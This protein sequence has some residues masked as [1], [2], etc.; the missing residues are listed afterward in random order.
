MNKDLVKELAF[1]EKHQDELVARHEGKFV[2]ISGEAVVGVYASEMEAYIEAQKTH[3]LGTF[4]I[5]QCIPGTEAYTKTF[6]SRVS[7]PR[8]SC[9]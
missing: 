1:F 9:R 7:F 2:V 5:Q 4:L 3:P 8:S 6:H